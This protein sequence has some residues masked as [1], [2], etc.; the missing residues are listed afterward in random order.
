MKNLTIGI[1]FLA[2]VVLGGL[3]VHQA[4]KASQ[5]Q[6]SANTLQQNVNDLQSTVAEQEQQATRLREQLEQTRTDVAAKNQEAAALQTQIQAAATNL[7][8]RVAA[9]SPS[10][11]NAKAANPFSAI[12]KNPEMKNVIKSSQQAVLGPMIDKNYARLF[13]DLH[14]TPE[15]TATL[16][17]IILNKQMGAAEMGLSMLSNEGET[18]RAAMMEQ[19]KKSTDAADAQ[20][21]EFL[22]DDNYGQ[23]QAYEKTM[24]E[25]MAVSGLKDKLAGGA[26][27]LTDIQ[28]QQLIQ[29]MGEERQ[30]FKFTTD[31]GDK[32]K[33]N[34]DFTSMFTEE[35]MNTYFTELDKLNQQYQAR[36]A[37]ILSPDQLTAFKDYLSGQQSMQKAGMQMAVKMFAPAKSEGE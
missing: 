9:K 16:K 4:R 3:Y 34:G 10:Q 1:L 27:P 23:F 37:G 29:A 11:T 15:Q 18:N 36:A 7:Q 25:R 22:G 6:T 24:G 28:E 33:F 26:A 32:S 21:K 5:V 20:I 17:D 8:A 31:Y 12:F 19:M 13:S 2:A 30:S 35:K 14:L